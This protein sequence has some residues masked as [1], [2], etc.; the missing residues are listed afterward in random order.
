MLFASAVFCRS[1]PGA[2]CQDYFKIVNGTCAQA[3]LG[4]SVGICPIGIVK[5]FGS[6]KPGDC[7]TSGYSVKNGTVDKVAGPCGRIR[8][9][10]YAKPTTPVLPNPKSTVAL[11]VMAVASPRCSDWAEAGEC[12]KNPSFMWAECAEACTA[13]GFKEPY[14][15]FDERALAGPPSSAQLLELSFESTAGLGLV[16]IVLRPDLAPATVKSVVDAVSARLAGDRIVGAVYRNEAMPTTAPEQCGDILCG[17]YALIQGRLE[18]LAGTPVEAAP[19]VR[20]GYVA[21][22]QRG[23]DFF[24]ALAGSHALRMPRLARR[25][26]SACVARPAPAAYPSRRPCCLLVPSPLLLAEAV[27]SAVC[28]CRRPCCLARADWLFPRC[29]CRPRRVGARVH[30]VGRGARRG[31]HGHARENSVA[32]VP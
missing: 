30:G 2:A 10:T 15:E 32:A 31:K 18:G 7:L 29:T 22:V 16:R 9:D 1:F 11:P 27:A 25:A 24:V 28:P 8:F 23:A 14:A 17:P 5:S 12:A 20:R 21:R 4:K 19:V 26:R 6:L 3:C 13:L